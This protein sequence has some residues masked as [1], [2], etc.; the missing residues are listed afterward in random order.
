MSGL[1][2]SIQGNG[3]GCYGLAVEAQRARYLRAG[4]TLD[5]GRRQGYS[6]GTVFREIRRPRR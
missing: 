1:R 3:V 4:L 2:E 5:N 6:L